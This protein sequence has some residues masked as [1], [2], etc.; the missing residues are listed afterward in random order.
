MFYT[1]LY[2]ITVITKGLVTFGHA[3]LQAAERADRAL[4]A[5]EFGLLQ[6]AR[7]RQTDFD[8]YPISLVLCGFFQPEE[9]KC[10]LAYE[11]LF[12]T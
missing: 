3:K 9:K 4:F 12:Y 7:H 2:A 11:I 10:F 1:Q 5:G 8:R 6:L